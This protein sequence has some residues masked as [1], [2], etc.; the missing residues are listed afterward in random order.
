MSKKGLAIAGAACAAFTGVSFVRA[1]NYK[2]LPAEAAEIEDYP[3]DVDKVCEHLSRAIQIKT[4]S[5]M[6]D[7][8]TDWSQFDEFHKFLEEAYPLIHKN[9]EKEVVG[10]ASL[11]FRWPGKDPSLDPV[12]FLSHQ[13]VVPISEGTEQDWEH[14]PWSGY[15]DGEII[16]GRGALD[17]KNHLICVCEAIESLMEQGF[18]PDRDVYLLFGHNE[19]QVSTGCSGAQEIVKTLQERGIHLDSTIDE[20]SALL[21][22]AVPG[23]IDSYLTAIG[24]AEKGFVN[25]KITLNTKGGH[26]SVSPKHTGV[27]ILA[28]TIR[29]IENHP[30]KTRWLPFMDELVDQ[31][32]R[33]TSLPVRMILVNFPILRPLVQ[34][35]MGQIPESAS[36]VHTVQGVTMVEGSMQPNVLPQR[37]SMTINF[38][39]LQG[40][41]IAD[42]VEH[43]R[44]VIKYDDYEL[45]T[46]DEKE[47]TRLCST[48]SRAYKAIEKVEHGLHPNNIAV[49]PYLV[50]GGTDS[51]NYEPICENCLRYAP[52]CV[53]PALL[54]TT[55]GTNERIPISCLKESV[56]FFREYCK[57]VAGKD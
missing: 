32:A 54:M 10:A 53:S 29:D 23:V 55:H 2:P 31:A 48:T 18:E 13:D 26:S 42:V 15:N 20:G 39:P 37:P 8:T 21:K 5:T 27:G 30:F 7:L 43:I 40:D 38:R 47:P 46:S 14:D 11:M 52:F 56:L 50:M 24:I 9:C 44:K 4:V 28:K 49:V 3:V 1:L 51:A 36:L 6:N 45:V 41:S 34:Y 12:A 22:V 57:I 35:V 25:M 33:M 19:E 17:M 16:W